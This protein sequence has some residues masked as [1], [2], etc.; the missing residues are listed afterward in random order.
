MT[1]PHRVVERTKDGQKVA[2]Y[3]NDNRADHYF[4]AESYDVLAKE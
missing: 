4:F 1:A 3:V 2:R